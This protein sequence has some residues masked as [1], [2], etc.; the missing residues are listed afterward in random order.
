ML[1]H[2][3]FC[4]FEYET[5]S[6]IQTAIQKINYFGDSF[7]NSSICIYCFL[8]WGQGSAISTGPEYR[9]HRFHKRNNGA[10][11][12]IDIIPVICICQSML[13]ILQ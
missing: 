2:V 12:N 9:T 8:V 13:D 11:S 10:D 3:K 4:I 5:W 6:S 1:K 7:S